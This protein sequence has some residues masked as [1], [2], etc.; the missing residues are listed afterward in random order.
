MFWGAVAIGC[1]SGAV[2][3]PR[4]ANPGFGIL[5]AVLVTYVLPAAYFVLTEGDFEGSLLADAF[6]VFAGALSLAA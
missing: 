5:W 6:F 3:T 4:D 2:T 1:L